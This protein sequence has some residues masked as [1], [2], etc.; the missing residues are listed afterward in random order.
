MSSIFPLWWMSTFLECPFSS[1]PFYCLIPLLGNKKTTATAE[2]K[3]AC[4]QLSI[5]NGAVNQ[6]LTFPNVHSLL[7][8]D[9]S[10][11]RLLVLFL[12]LRPE[13]KVNLIRNHLCILQVSSRLPSFKSFSSFCS[14]HHREWEMKSSLPYYCYYHRIAWI[15]IEQ[16]SL[17]Y[18]TRLFISLLNFCNSFRIFFSSCGGRRKEAKTGGG[19]RMSR[20]VCAPVVVVVFP[21]LDERYEQ[22]SGA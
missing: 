7:L 11:S 14:S 6:T 22:L 10:S 17:S 2:M 20:R 15:E 13:P 5:P 1:I 12:F 18:V 21:V 3:T 8:R 19:G 9:Y 16:Q 4:R